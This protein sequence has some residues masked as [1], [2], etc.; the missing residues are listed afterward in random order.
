MKKYFCFTMLLTAALL[1]LTA[2]CES[3]AKP[4]EYKEINLPEVSIVQY[5]DGPTLRIAGKLIRSTHAVEKIRQTK[6]GRTMLVEV[7]AAPFPRD[8][9]TGVFS[10]EVILDDLDFVVFGPGRTLIWRRHPNTEP[11]RERPKVEFKAP[12]E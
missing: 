1:L 7:L 12:E 5:S 9:H 11:T 6:Q 3:F 10:T 2:G 4:I 8:G